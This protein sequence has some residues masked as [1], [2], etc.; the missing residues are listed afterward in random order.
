VINVTWDDAQ[1]YCA[2]LMAETGEYY[3]LP[4]EAEWEY[5]ARSG[6][7]DDKW[8]GTSDEAEVGEYAWYKGNKT[9]PVG[10]KRPNGMGLFDMS[11]NVCE[12]CQDVYGKYPDGAVVDPVGPDAGSPRVFRGGFWSCPTWSCRSACRD[13]LA[14]GLRLCLLGF[15]LARGQQAG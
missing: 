6:G 13:K 11:G 12:W 7:G 2:W 1:A 10:E 14:P 9:H 15:R 8:A 3:R 4:T 5:A